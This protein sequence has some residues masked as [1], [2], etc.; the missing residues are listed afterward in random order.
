MGISLGSG[1]KVMVSAATHLS[2]TTVHR[3]IKE[4]EASSKV[5]QDLKIRAG[6]G[7][8]QISGFHST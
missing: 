1:G 5:A 7:G 3:G 6:G 4:L 8:D 2:R